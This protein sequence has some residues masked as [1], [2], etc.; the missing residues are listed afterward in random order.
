MIIFQAHN[1]D[2]PVSRLIRVFSPRYNHISI[3]VG[4][5][6]YEAHAIKGVTKTAYGSWKD[7]KSV[8]ATM[9]FDVT[10]SV[11]ARV[12]EFLE[13]QVGK[14]YDGHGIFSF[15]WQYSKPVKGKWYCSELAMATLYKMINV[16]SNSEN[17]NQKVSPAKFWDKVTHLYKIN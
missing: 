5:T 16:K 6:V 12:K 9:G 2:K 13:R 4:N 1:G 17:Y 3:R 8:V 10:A 7:K 11:Q 15:L 14:K